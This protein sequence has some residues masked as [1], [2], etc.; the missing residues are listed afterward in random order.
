MDAFRAS[1][2]FGADSEI[3]ENATGSE[4]GLNRSR[5]YPGTPE[6]SES[7]F[8][9]LFEILPDAVYV[10]RDKKIVYVN[11]AGVR[12]YGAAGPEELLGRS[13]FDFIPFD[14]R[15]IIAARMDDMV[16]RNVAVPLLEQER[17]R[18]DG[19]RIDVEVAACPC[20]WEGKRSVLVVSRDIRER[21]KT[22]AALRETEAQLHGISA[23]LPGMVYQR[24]R[25]PDGRVEFPY[26]SAGVRDVLGVEPDAAMED[27]AV[28]LDL[29]HPDDLSNV[30]GA[31]ERSAEAGE[32]LDIEFRIVQPSGKH[33]WVRGI[34]RPRP[35]DDGA[36]VWD[37][38]MFDVTERKEFESALQRSEARYRRLLETSPDAIY[39]HFRDRIVYGNEAAVAMF[40]AQ[41]RDEL[42]G[43]AAHTLYHPDGLELLSECRERIRTSG[44][45]SEPVEFRLRRLDGGEFYGEATAMEVDWEGEPAIFVIIRD[46]SDRHEAE[47]VMERLNHK[48]LQQT[49]ELRRSNSDLEQFAYIASHDLQ[50]PL[51]MISGYCQLLQRRY[52][53]KLDGDANEFIEF[54]VE[55]AGRMQRLIS[56]I[57][58][59]SRVSTRGQ[60]MTLVDMG[61]IFA[62][63][64][65]NLKTGIDETRATVT[66]DPMPLVKAD[67]SQIGQVLQNLIGNAL[68][69]RG[70]SPPRIHLGVR[71]MEDHWEFSVSDNGIGIEPKYRDRIFLIFQRLHNRSEYPGT[72]IGLAVCQKIV[73]RH[74]G[75]IRIEDAEDGGSK[76]LF[77]IPKSED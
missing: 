21:K 37:A 49:R 7:Q 60:P 47:R 72:G 16:R 48:L 62:D 17:L 76:F 30:M 46:V 77:T 24:V 70:K 14:W 74:G 71:D 5:A 63:T 20:M 38:M 27:P 12:L 52:K 44:R 40:R 32:Q 51:R 59:Y 57:L 6:S 68:K 65:A 9:E 42:I 15:E 75:T 56:D 36:I 3:P 4:E 66:A 69:F 54:A 23:N 26:V 31:I 34:S 22:E 1:E 18:L 67:G 35:R 39:V 13:T 29:I 2:T 8:R 11:S 19:T 43:R 28:M 73:Y 10:H 61:K 45:V 55:G 58:T 50:E 33:C 25:H 41:D 64:I 53:D